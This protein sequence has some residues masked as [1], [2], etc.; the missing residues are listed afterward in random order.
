MQASVPSVEQQPHCTERR[1]AGERHRLMQTRAGKPM[2]RLQMQPQTRCI[3]ANSPCSAP[4]ACCSVLTALPRHG[5]FDISKVFLS[6]GS[7]LMGYSLIWIHGPPIQQSAG[8]SSAINRMQLQLLWSH[9]WCPVQVKEAQQNYDACRASPQTTAEWK[10]RKLH[11]QLAVRRLHSKLSQ[12]VQALAAPE[13]I[14]ENVRPY[15]NELHT[16]IGAPPAKLELSPNVRCMFLRVKAYRVHQ[17]IG[18][19][20]V[21]V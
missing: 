5:A 17:S 19:R 20:I 21:L 6:C 11:L 18:T 14:P 15:L 4:Q 10:V 12:Q 3:L 13:V 1:K 7:V 9:A 2:S 16:V 8:H